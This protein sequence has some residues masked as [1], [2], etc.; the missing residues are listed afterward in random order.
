VSF[1]QS[2]G[3]MLVVEAALSASFMQEA[4]AEVQ[5]ADDAAAVLL[6]VLRAVPRG[7]FRVGINEDETLNGEGDVH[8]LILLALHFIGIRALRGMRAARAVLAAGY[9]PEAHALDRVL[10]ELQAHRGAILADATGAEALAWVRGKRRSREKGWDGISARVKTANPEAEGLYGR[11]SQ[12]SHGDPAPA[13][14]LIDAEDGQV[15]LAPRRTVAT[16]A[17]LLFH[18]GFARDQAGLIADRAGGITVQGLED[19]AEA[20]RAAWK[21]L[22]EEHS[23]AAEAED[24]NRAHR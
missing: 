18:A 24:H 16:R 5:L 19:L 20:I 21:R 22:E 10:I 2:R 9:E 11:L 6:A 8:L 15:Q 3:E 14:G 17:S 13:I 1:E 4:S 7:T 12:D 23:P